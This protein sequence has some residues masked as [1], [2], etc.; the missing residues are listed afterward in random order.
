MRNIDDFEPY[1]YSKDRDLHN[2]CGETMTP[3]TEQWEA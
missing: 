2:P 1:I 3:D